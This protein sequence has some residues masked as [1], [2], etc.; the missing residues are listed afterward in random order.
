MKLEKIYH[1]GHRNAW[2][3]K[4]VL[5]GLVFKHKFK[6]DKSPVLLGKEREAIIRILTVI[7]EGE[8]IAW[9]T[10]SL[11]AYEL[12]DTGAKMAATSQAHDEA[13]HFYVLRD[14]IKQVLGHNPSPIDIAP[15]ARRG[16]EI[17]DKAPTLAAKLLGMQLLVEPVAITLFRQLR[18]KNVEPVL[19]DL[20]PYYEKDEARHIALGVVALPAIIEKMNWLSIVKLCLWQIKVLRA[21]A[22]GLRSMTPYLE[23]LEIDPLSVFKEAEMRQIFAVKEMEEN[24]TLKIP[25]SRLISLAFA[26]ERQLIIHKSFFGLIKSK[27]KNDS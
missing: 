15:E 25:L 19:V 3:G 13:R 26:Y 10:S 6:I 22:H 20:L 1:K 14:Y 8:R 18:K 5:D 27:I 17:V 23:V 11:L 21:E 7:L 4:K 16:L 24:L 9:R 2:D 12:E